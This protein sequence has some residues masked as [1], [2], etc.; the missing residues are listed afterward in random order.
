MQALSANLTL[1]VLG[2]GLGPL[3]TQRVVCRHQAVTSLCKKVTGMDPEQPDAK[4]PKN[5]RSKASH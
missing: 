3:C 4:H 5:I 2:S 1:E